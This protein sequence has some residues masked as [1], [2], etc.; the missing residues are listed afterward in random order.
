[1]SGT[2]ITPAR[3]LTG[4]VRFTLGAGC[5][6]FDYGGGSSPDNVA[7]T[8]VIQ[9]K[10]TSVHVNQKVRFDGSRSF[11]AED[12]PTQLT[13]EWDFDGNGVSDATG[14]EATHRYT[15]AGSYVA[16]LK[17]TD[18]GGASGT[19]TLAITVE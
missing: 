15:A 1:M 19:A 14:R 3:N 9:T 8:A 5:A 13:Y 11:D 10:K 7:P 4:D 16:T 2:D 17:V 18:T 6:D 12:A